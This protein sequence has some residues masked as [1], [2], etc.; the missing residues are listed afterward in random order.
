MWNLQPNINLSILRPDISET[1]TFFGFTLFNISI[2]LPV[3][4]SVIGIPV[5]LSCFFFV[6]FLNLLLQLYHKNLIM[7]GLGNFYCFGCPTTAWKT[8]FSFSRHPEKMVFQKKLHW[9]MIFLVLLGK[10][11][12]LFPENM[13]LF[14]RQKMKDDLSPKKIHGNMIFSSNVLKRWSFQ[15]NCAGI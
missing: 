5:F 4:L 12:F 7:I 1:K 3:K 11:K 8:I 9:N 10:M 6:F 15:N 2:R 13:I 14:F